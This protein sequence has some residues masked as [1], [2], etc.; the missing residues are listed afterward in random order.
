LSAATIFGKRQS[1]IGQKRQ[2]RTRMDKVEF[3][4]RQRIVNQVMAQHLQI[5]CIDRL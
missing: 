2:E 3:P 1:R 5:G 4:F